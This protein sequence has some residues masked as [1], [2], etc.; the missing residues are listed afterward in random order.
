MQRFYAAHLPIVAL[1]WD[2]LT[3]GASSKLDNM[4]VDNVFGLNNV[5]NWL[6]I[7]AK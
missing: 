1:Y 2:A 5:Q 7:T 6:N 4:V 3:Y